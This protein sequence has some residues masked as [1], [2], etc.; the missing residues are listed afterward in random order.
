MFLSL[1]YL[2]FILILYFALK[3]Y[4]YCYFKASKSGY[5]MDIKEE[6]NIMKNKFK[7]PIF[8]LTIFLV[9]I[10]LNNNT[11][12]ENLPNKSLKYLQRGQSVKEVQ[13]VLNK[14]GYK[15]TT[16]GIYGAKTKSAILD[17]QKK[18]PKLVNDGI[19]G[20]ATRAA[21]LKALN[22]N[23]TSSSGNNS[24]PLKGKVAYLTFDDGPSKTVTPKILK[25]LDNYNIKSTF[26]V[27]GSMAEKNP[28]I[29][30]TIKAKGHSIGHHSYSHNYKYLYGNTN[31]FL[32]EVNRT[33]RIFKNILGQNFNTRLLRFPGGS[34]E[35]YKNPHKKVFQSKGYKIYDWNALN[36]DSEARNVSVNTQLARLKATTRGQKELIVLMHDA[37]GKENTAKALPQIIEYLK[38][39]GYT[40]RA[41]AQ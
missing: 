30:K 34:F 37:S 31:N 38:A 12:A 17:F 27:L 11:Y 16:D 28:S 24:I 19:Y 26:F 6:L 13:I 18:D 8:L 23:N 29:L 2:D 33:S 10:S 20:P 9:F 4:L 32:G 22:G 14:L 41:L 7:L 3:L 1:V 39:Q 21:L 15:L 25:T 5:R 40:F 35:S 36:G